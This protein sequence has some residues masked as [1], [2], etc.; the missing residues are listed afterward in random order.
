MSEKNFLPRNK[1]LRVASRALRTGATKQE[2]HLW[3][4]FL[5][6]LSPRFSRQR[7]IGNFMVDFYCHK[8]SL[9]IELD[10]AQHCEPEAMEYDNARTEYLNGLGIKVLRFANKE[11]D[12]NFSSV[13][14]CITQA[15]KASF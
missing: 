10:G 8:A 1:N 4:D 9:A 14:E 5:K 3:H 15:I 7:I 11:I 13:C 6:Y 12:E 2:N